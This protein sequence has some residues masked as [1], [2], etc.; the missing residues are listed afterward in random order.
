MTSYG[1]APH[2]PELAGI[3]QRLWYVEDP[4]STGLEV[5]LP[6][7]TAQ[8]LINLSGD[9]LSCGGADRRETVGP[10]A[11]ASI[12]TGPQVLDRTE[13]R[14]LVGVVIRPE[15]IGGLARLPADA[16]G[17]L[18]AL[19]E[20]WGG[21]AERLRE[22]AEPAAGGAEALDRVEAELVQLARP[23]DGPVADP[24]VRQVIDRLRRNERIGTIGDRVGLSQS[25]WTRRFRTAVGLSPKRYQRV[26]RL[27]RVIALAREGDAGRRDWADL[28][29]TAGYYDQAHLVGDFTELTGTSPTRWFR[30]R[31]EVAFHGPLSAR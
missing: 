21:W 26:L 17:P 12:Q 14:R 23:G 3:V 1:R 27:E 7:S 30:G 20:L 24:L 9:R 31:P 22:V 18:A 4:G 28:A 25:S 10:Y 13:Q 19:D 11:L 15:A 6:T 16:I 8:L 5:K 29:I 2:R